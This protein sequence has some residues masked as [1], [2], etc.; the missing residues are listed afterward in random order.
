MEGHPSGERVYPRVRK[1]HEKPIA[2][3][4]ALCG[5]SFSRY[6]SQLS[7][8][9]NFCSRACSYRHRSTVQLPP[10]DNVSAEVVEFWA[11]YYELEELRIQK[12][13]DGHTLDPLATEPRMD[14]KDLVWAIREIRNATP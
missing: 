4:C 5:R 1:S 6:V 2:V 3:T 9:F 11:F 13:M 10:K 14:L 7:R 12:E 8:T